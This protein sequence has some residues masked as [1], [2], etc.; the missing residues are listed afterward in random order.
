MTREEAK[1]YATSGD[2]HGGR[3]ISRDA[4]IDKI[5]DGFES[6]TCKT[7]TYGEPF[8]NTAYAMVNCEIMEQDVANTYYCNSYERREDDNTTK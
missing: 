3:A 5:Y 4:L 8:K 2:G 6:R 1:K 7:C